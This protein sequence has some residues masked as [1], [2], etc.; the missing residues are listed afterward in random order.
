MPAALSKEEQIREQVL[1]AAQQLFQQHGLHKVTMDDIA[2]ALGRG[3][4]SLYYYY[5]SKEEIFTAMLDREI[6]EVL[7][8]VAQAVA[9]APTVE[10][11]LYTFCMT[12]L[13]KQRQKAALNALVAGEALRS[14]DLVHHIRQ[15]YRQQQA[16]LLRQIFAGAAGSS[17]TS[18]CPQSVEALTVLILAGLRGLGEEL[19]FSDSLALVEPA[20]RLLCRTLATAPLL[21]TTSQPA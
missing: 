18:A 1:C 8:E 14:L 7:A 6:R 16:D 3:K 4:S 19:V 11:K 13:Q 12:R 10:E 15:C 17:A 9:L 20:I 21:P 2:R 5:K